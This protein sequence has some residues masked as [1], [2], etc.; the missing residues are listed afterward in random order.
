[1]PQRL[2][3]GLL[4]TALLLPVPRAHADLFDTARKAARTDIGQADT[5]G[6]SIRGGVNMPTGQ[7]GNTTLFRTQSQVGGTCGSF[8]FRGSMQQAFTELPALFES[9]LQEVLSE[10]P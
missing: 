4:L 5:T 2:T 8:D 7:A 6:V 3:T 1:M 10:M 9:L